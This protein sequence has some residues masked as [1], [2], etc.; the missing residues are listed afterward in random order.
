[1]SEGGDTSPTPAA[2]A[3][4]AEESAPANTGAE[5]EPATTGAA[6]SKPAASSSDPPAPPGGNAGAGAGGAAGANAGD[7]GGLQ[8]VAANMV[9]SITAYANAEMSGTIWIAIAP[10]THAAPHHM[11]GDRRRVTT[12]GQEHTCS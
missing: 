4:A 5:S 1:M 2:A 12:G 7:D 9:D 6:L 11:S 3:A 8:R 10:R